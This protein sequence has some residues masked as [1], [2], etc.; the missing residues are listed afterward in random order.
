MGVLAT[1]FFLLA[2]TL[3]CIRPSVALALLILMFPIEQLLQAANPFLLS[4]RFGLIAVNALTAIVA[5]FAL[6]RVWLSGAQP[7]RAVFSAAFVAACLLLAWSAASLAWTPSW[8]LASSTVPQALPYMLLT[9]GFG[10]FLL[11]DLDAAD[12]MLKAILVLG[13][14]LC[15]FIIVNPEFQARWGRL[16]LDLGG[17][18][19]SSPLA[20]GEAGGMTVILSMLLRHQQGWS[21][22]AW[23]LLRLVGVLAGL[24]LGIQSGSRGQILFAVAVGAGFYTF[25][26][27]LRDIRRTVLTVLGLGFLIV[28]AMILMNTLLYGF[29][30][31]R[32]SPEELLYGRSSTMGRVQNV[33]VLA[34]AWADR[35]L[36]WIFGLGFLAFNALYSGQIDPYSHVVIA[37]VIFEEGLVGVLLGL[38]TLVY[39]GRD[40]AYL[41]KSYAADRS[42]R[43]TAIAL[44]ALATYSFL[45]ANK[46]GH[47]WG[48]SSTFFLLCTAARL[49]LR[50]DSG[51]APA[52]LSRDD[53]AHDESLEPDA[54]SLSPQGP[55]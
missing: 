5:I 47:L 29:D 54:A 45:L 50:I 38:A 2:F 41:V 18:I 44:L 53:V 11:T 55:R 51:L 4:S 33:M 20:L 17:G 52:A 22:V 19:R 6:I 24:Y 8:E 49:R 26:A 27:P 32:F 37:D 46:Q 16:G 25:A 3:G 13:T 9:F 30:A 35:P 36:A 39:A 31:Q 43:V 40:H 12:R 1:I 42:L 28:S 7:L 34:S 23:S 48:I 21:T 15:C 10:T 14:A